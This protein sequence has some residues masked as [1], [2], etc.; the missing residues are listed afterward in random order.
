MNRDMLSRRLRHHGFHGGYRG[1]RPAAL[2][3][4]RRRQSGSG[5]ARYHDAGHDRHGSVARTCVAPMPPDQLPVIMVTAVS[6]SDKVVEALDLGANDYI[7][8]PVDFPVA[9]ARIR[10]QLAR[11]GRRSGFAGERGAL[12]AG[13]PRR[14]RR[15]VGLGPG[16]G[17]VY[18]SDPMESHARATGSA[19]SASGP[20]EWFSR[21]HPDDLRKV[22]G[23]SMR[24]RSAGAAR[25]FECEHRMRHR[26]GTYR[27]MLLSRRAVQDSGG[28]VVAHGRLH[29]RR[30]HEQSLRPTHR[31]SQPDTLHGT[32][33]QEFDGIGANR[34]SPD[35]R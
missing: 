10:S 17:R 26:D 27:W 20:D 23:G 7:T 34:R 35:S 15:P 3:I 9:L 24:G 14:Q 21:V 29:E 12:R 1:R 16:T 31:A 25:R 28:Q 11:K 30:H 18:Y 4:H 22:A 6:E 5:P 8:K 13:G 19:K 2:A 33:E 32:L